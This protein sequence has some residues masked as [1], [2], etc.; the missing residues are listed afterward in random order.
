VYGTVIRI[1][2]EASANVSSDTDVA[3]KIYGFDAGLT[4][5]PST[6]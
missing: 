2:L 6:V 3:V 4:Q 1:R 5:I